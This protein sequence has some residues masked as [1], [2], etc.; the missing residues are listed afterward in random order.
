MP[1]AYLK[2][3][4]DVLPTIQ[5]QYW[6][7]GK[8]S[9]ESGVLAAQVAARSNKGARETYWCRSCGSY[10]IGSAIGSPSPKAA[11]AELVR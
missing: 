2:G 7:A 3:P 5:I 10:H 1:P 4:A 8:Q 6:C 11:V 9:F